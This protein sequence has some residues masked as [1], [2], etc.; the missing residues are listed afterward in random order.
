MRNLK[1]EEWRKNPQQLTEIG[2]Q[3]CLD[4]IPIC[5]GFGFISFLERELLSGKYMKALWCFF[6][7]YSRAVAEVFFN[8]ASHSW[9]YVCLFFF[10]YCENSMYFAQDRYFFGH[11]FYQRKFLR[12]GR[13]RLEYCLHVNLWNSLSMDN[14]SIMWQ[15]LRIACYVCKGQLQQL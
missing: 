6:S 3:I 8:L 5:F 14:I 10:T 13:N 15:R 9:A 4:C 1:V 7:R 2:K 12:R 11:S